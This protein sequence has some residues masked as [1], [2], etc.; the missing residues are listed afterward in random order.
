[1]LEADWKGDLAAGCTGEL[2]AGWTG[3]LN[4]GVLSASGFYEGRTDM[5]CG[6]WGHGF[7]SLNMCAGLRRSTV[8]TTT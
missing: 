6:S 3:V 7:L 1:M 8:T 5:R 2:R 4:V